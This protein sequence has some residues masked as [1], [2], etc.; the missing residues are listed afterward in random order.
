MISLLSRE[1][2]I[3]RHSDYVMCEDRLVSEQEFLSSSMRSVFV[4]QGPV[5]YSRSTELLCLLFDFFRHLI[6]SF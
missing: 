3:T 4:Q 1:D 2:M 6:L 5:L